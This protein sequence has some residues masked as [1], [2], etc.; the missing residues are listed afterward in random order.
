MR[1]G[2]IH[3]LNS[4]Q[5]SKK[6]DKFPKMLKHSF[7]IMQKQSQT[8]GQFRSCFEAFNCMSFRIPIFQVFLVHIGLKPKVQSSFLTLKTAVEKTISP[9]GPFSSC[10]RA[11]SCPFW[12]FTH[13]VKSD[14]QLKISVHAILYFV[15]QGLQ[16]PITSGA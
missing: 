15:L 9:H 13:S 8:K 7:K 2:S 12:P 5:E 1:V 14:L 11:F 3:S 6:A 16:C 10:C 4:Q